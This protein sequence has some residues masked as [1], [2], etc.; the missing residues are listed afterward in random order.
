MKKQ[1]KYKQELNIPFEFHLAD[2]YYE[3]NKWEEGSE[4]FFRGYLWTYYQTTI[5]ITTNI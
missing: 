2:G 3:T 1:E 4:L 5:K